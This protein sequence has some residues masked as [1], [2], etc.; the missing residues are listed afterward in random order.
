MPEFATATGVIYYEELGPAAAQ[1]TVLL[2][3]NF[4]STGR[5]AWGSIAKDLA[6]RYRVIVPDLPGHGRSVGHPPGFAHREMAEQIAALLAALGV[7]APHVAGASG[8]GMAA[9][10]LIHAHLPD[11][12]TLTLVSSTYST[13]AAATGVPVNLDP[14]D[15]RGGRDWLAATARL[16]DEHQG[17]GYFE[18]VLLP[19]LHAW[20]PATTVD[21][22][23]ATLRGWRLPVCLIHGAAD[24][25][26]PALLAEQMHAALPD[27]ELHLIPGAGHALLLQRPHVVSGILR[28]F[29]ARHIRA[30]AQK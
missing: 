23:L 27:S 28:T 29:L 16:H 22:S 4:L 17:A 12:A 26:F 14:E 18:T 9:Q 30:V 5:V 21:F 6:Q 19:A 25:I 13:D 7:T 10:W 11:A 1:G 3:H 2:L 24:E 20:T 15:F 8:G